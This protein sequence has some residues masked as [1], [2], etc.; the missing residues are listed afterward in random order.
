VTEQT[1]AGSST[2]DDTRAQTLHSDDRG[3]RGA[4]EAERAYGELIGRYVILSKL[5][6]GGMGVVYAAYDPELDR[7]L[8]LKLLLTARTE[9]AESIGRARLLREAQALAKL[10]HPHV[11]AVHDVGEHHGDVWIAMEFVEG[12]TLAAWLAAK[13]RSWRERVAVLRAAGEGLAAAHAKGMLHRDVK[14]DNIMVSGDGRVR[15]MDFGLAR[16]EH[17][18][19]VITVA[20]LESG[21]AEAGR[22]A[23]EVTQA[24][25][26]VGTPAYMSPEQ[27][28]GEELT[29]AADQFSF[30]VTCWEAL[31]GER[32][33]AGA[34]VYELAANVIEGQIRTPPR[35]DAPSWLHALVR[36]GLEGEPAARHA[37]MQALL[38]A[39]ASGEARTR[40]KRGLIAG[41][42]TV[43]ALLAGIAGAVSLQR[44][45]LARTTQACV[46]AGAAIEDEWNSDT[47]ARLRAGLLATEVSYAESTADKVLPYF[48]AQ[49]AAWREATTSAC[50]ATRVDQTWTED[51]L[52]RANWCLDERR[53]ELVALR[54]EL[55]HTDREGVQRAIAAA[56]GMGL[57]APCSDLNRLARA[58][59]LPDDRESVRRVRA[60]LSKAAALRAAGRPVE[61]LELASATEAEAEALRWAPLI[62]AAGVELG[63]ARFETGDYPGAERNFEDAYFLAR[64][65]NTDEVAATASIELISTVGDRLARGPEG[66]RWSRHAN[67]ALDDLGE[68]DDGLRRAN[69]LNA[70]GN[71]DYDLGEYAEAKARYAAA[72]AIREAALGR[73]HPRVAALLNNL[74]IVHARL[75]EY[76]QAK[77]RGE[78]GLAVA[79]RALGP[80]HPDV[81][82]ALTNL[83]NVYADLGELD[84][85]KRHYERALAIWEHALGPEHPHVAMALNN[86][87]IVY[88]DL[89]QP[90]EAKLRYERALTIWEQTLGP[91]HPD[92]AASLNNL[93]N[94]YLE[95]DELDAGKA[96]FERALAIA[97]PAL[98]P[99]HPEL[100]YSLQ[101]LG[102]VA[103]RSGQVGDAVPLLERG[104]TLRTVAKLDAV[105]TVELGFALAQALWDAP[106][107]AGQDRDRARALAEQARDVYAEAP[108]SEDAHARVEAWLAEHPIERVR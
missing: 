17:G 51:L 11:V 49:A 15:V 32:P 89:G 76:E 31:Y 41:S 22:L 100:A 93:G 29:A 68:P 60:K 20:E 102:T 8:A 103:R 106:V 70:V 73:E 83:G 44:R 71:V 57:V 80:D 77:A 13:P 74:A 101:G 59:A 45:E 66:L 6:A 85:A 10:S 30:C 43:A 37:D 36:K 56:A 63:N 7:K 67:S 79:E 90:S 97:E 104:F 64:D 9:A 18:R 46:A 108:G 40:R 86:L 39:L 34:N 5:G 58:V 88:M 94:V 16:A 84:T 55:S 78:Q 35:T 1:L 23:V 25:S 33:F 28:R 96:Q 4:V 69:W 95:L 62:A 98:G 53:M 27:L 99:D 21:E 52:D 14:P 2:V 26:M 54:D 24:G 50:M 105:L 19:R 91:D 72:L 92:L 42:L 3:V 107:D 61:A 47:R 38:A 82:L 65:N 87:G 75:G 81:A 48:D 12:Q